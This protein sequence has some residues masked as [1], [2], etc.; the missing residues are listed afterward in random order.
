M[1]RDVCLTLDKVDDLDVFPQEERAPLVA[2]AENILSKLTL[3]LA[4]VRL[5]VGQSYLLRVHIRLWSLKSVDELSHNWHGSRSVVIRYDDTYRLS[6]I[7]QAEVIADMAP[8]F[9]HC[10]DF[11]YK[12]FIKRVRMALRKYRPKGAGLCAT[13]RLTTGSDGACTNISAVFNDAAT[14]GLINVHPCPACQLAHEDGV[15]GVIAKYTAI[16]TD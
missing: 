3:D 4:F 2:A 12:D 8:E 1:I 13:V 7:E 10:D 15:A 11:F 16:E 5:L 6:P 9:R 14:R